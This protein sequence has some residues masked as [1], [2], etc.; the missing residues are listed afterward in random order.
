MKN[1]DRSLVKKIILIFLFLFS[2]MGCQKHDEEVF[3]NGYKAGFDEARNLLIKEIDS[4]NAKLKD[5]KDAINNYYS[6]GS[7][8]GG[9]EVNINGKVVKPDKDG[10][11][12]Y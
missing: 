4:C 5:E 8:C 2:V 1:I 9:G 6:H 10:C 7:V 11:V 3:N 12:R